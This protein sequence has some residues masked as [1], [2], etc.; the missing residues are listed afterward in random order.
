M[1]VFLS[2]A[3]AERQRVELIRQNLAS[4]GLDVFFDVDGIDAGAEFP[5]AI[6]HALR[7][8]KVVL[9]CWS[10][11]YF[12]R[13]WCLIESRVALAAGRLVPIAVERLD[14][15]APP[16]D[17]RFVN[18]L[19]LSEWTGEQEHSGWQTTLRALLRHLDKSEVEASLVSAAPQKPR[20]A[21]LTETRT[22]CLRIERA[23]QYSLAASTFEL[24]WNGE[25]IGDLNN[26]NTI[27]LQLRPGTGRFQLGMRHAIGR[28]MSFTAPLGLALTGGR[29]TFL[30]LKATPNLWGSPPIDFW[31]DNQRKAERRDCESE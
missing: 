27:E 14:D 22:A 5:E 9:A 21:V 3:R 11:L 29:T 28:E 15:Q 7:T 4:I 17:L 1:D 2:Y 13:R 31:I 19:D 6:D 20:G 8:C 18:Y 25:R 26:G 10:P 24:F 16:A 30:R 23:R 12:T